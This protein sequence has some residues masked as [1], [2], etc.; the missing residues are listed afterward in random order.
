MKNIPNNTIFFSI[1][2]ILSVFMGSC[3]EDE[4]LHLAGYPD[5]PV[6]LYITGL[7]GKPVSAGFKGTYNANGELVTTG[8]ISRTYV[9][10]LA[11][12]SPEDTHFVVEPI[13][14]NLPEDKV[15]ISDTRFTIPA[16]FTTRE[17]TV[18]L[19]DPSI[20][21]SNQSEI[22]YELGLRIVSVD[23]YKI[24]TGETEARV[25]LEKEAYAVNISLSGDDGRKV[26]FAR[27]YDGGVIVDTDPIEYTFRAYLDKPAGSD[28]KITFN[29]T[30][31]S[32]QYAGDVTVTPIEVVIPAGEKV[33]GEVEWT[34]TTDFMSTG[35]GYQQYDLA[36]TPSY[37]TEDPTV[38]LSATDATIDITVIR[39]I[40]QLQVVTSVQS[41][42]TLFNRSGWTGQASSGSV[43]TLLDGSTSS[44]INTAN[45]WVELDMQE[46]KNIAGFAVRSYLL[47]SYAPN[48]LVFYASDDGENW[49]LL[50][51]KNH[52]SRSTAYY[53]QLT[54]AVSSRYLRME[55]SY[56]TSSF[57]VAEIEVYGQ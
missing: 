19:T 43:S 5:T 38:G 56:G 33:S 45:L 44:Y 34:I 7:D 1:L 52:S 16:G 29:T 20:L 14:V 11:A 8:D 21:D 24:A 17:I 40:D 23:G 35:S 12:P 9:I 57:R 42:W 28:I 48:R 4:K 27:E 25:V 32:Q 22:T 54:S 18:E 13:I 53:Y 3:M 50:G 37:Q 47:S 10:R 39:Y 55:A 15:T 6:Q 49:I 30:G 26:S 36:V 2:L 31:I 41:G 46:S 51:V